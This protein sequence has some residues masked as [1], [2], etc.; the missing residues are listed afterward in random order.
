[1][2]PKQADKKVRKLKRQC[3]LLW[4]KYFKENIKKPQYIDR[5]LDITLDP[6]GMPQYGKYQGARLLCFKNKYLR[7]FGY[8]LIW[9]HRFTKKA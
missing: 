6:I 7:I 1:M 5:G 2:T 4:Y 3:V 9:K 8:R